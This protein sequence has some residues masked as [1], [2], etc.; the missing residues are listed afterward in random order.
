[1]VFMDPNKPSPGPATPQKAEILKIDMNRQFTYKGRQV[2]ITDDPLS[3][4][5]LPF[6]VIIDGR[7]RTAVW[8]LSDKTEPAESFAKRLIDVEALTQEIQAVKKAEARKTQFEYKGHQVEILG[9]PDAPSLITVNGKDRMAFWNPDNANCAATQV[10]SHLDAQLRSE[11]EFK[12]RDLSAKANAAGPDKKA[13]ADGENAIA[14][15]FGQPARSP[16]EWVAEREALNAFKAFQRR[17]RVAK[18]IHIV[19]ALIFCSL[20]NMVFGTIGWSWASWPVNIIGGIYI[21]GTL[22]SRGRVPLSGADWQEW[23]SP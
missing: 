22:F 13:E 11:L 20:A 18:A 3:D 7:D 6:K 9:D 16:S 5:G 4:F 14:S 15:I 10:K 17:N 1:M 23:K 19:C 8:F 21:A 2:E 12:I